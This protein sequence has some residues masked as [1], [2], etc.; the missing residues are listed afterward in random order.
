MKLNKK[1]KEYLLSCVNGSLAD[2]ERF[3]DDYQSLNAS[4]EIQRLRELKEKILLEPVS[5]FCE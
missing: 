2:R 4:E 3:T 5:A 1:E